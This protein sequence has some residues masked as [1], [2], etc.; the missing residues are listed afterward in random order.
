MKFVSGKS[1]A[2]FLLA[3][4]MSSAHAADGVRLGQPSYGGTGCPGGSASVSLSPDASALSILFDSYVV[5]AGGRKRIDRK[6]CN[7][8]IPIQVPQGYS[9]S[10]VALDYRGFLDLPSGARAQLSVDYFLAGN[11]RGVRTSKAFTSRDNGEYFKTDKL[12][13]EAVVWSDC[14]ASTILRSNTS[15]LA[16]TNARGEQA[17]ATVDSVDVQAGVIYQL[18]WKRCSR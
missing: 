12:G 15:L 7:I 13:L 3:L 14:G 18:Q 17:M 11:G 1:F 16:Q 5:E 8:A 2:F 4:G 9:Y 6:N 10:V